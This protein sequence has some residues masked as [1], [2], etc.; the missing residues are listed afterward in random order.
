MS[1]NFAWLTSAGG[2]NTI[3]M[4][5]IPPFIPAKFCYPTCKDTYHV[6]GYAESLFCTIVVRLLGSLTAAAAPA[7]TLYV[8]HRTAMTPGRANCQCGTPWAVTGHWP[9]WRGPATPCGG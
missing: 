1:T 5:A 3:V 4:L 8:A 7:V 2:P 6:C 9:P